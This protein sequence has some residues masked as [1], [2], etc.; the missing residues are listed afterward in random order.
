MS[1]ASLMGKARLNAAR[2]GIMAEDNPVKEH[3]RQRGEMRSLSWWFKKQEMTPARRGLMV[4][5]WLVIGALVYFQFAGGSHP[6]NAITTSKSAAPAQPALATA[7]KLPDAGATGAIDAMSAA[8]MPPKEVS[9]INVIRKARADYA[10][11]STDMQKGAV[12]PRRAKAIRAALQAPQVE[13]WIGRAV[14]ITTNGE[15]KGVLTVAI[16]DN[17]TLAT[18]NNA[19]SDIGSNTLVEADTPVYEAMLT[20]SKGDLVRFSGRFFK[21]DEDGIDE[22]SFT[23]TGSIEEPEFTFRF[24]ALEKVE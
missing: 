9:F 5:A 20:L 22:Q 3:E 1:G 4:V 2:G 15:G 21:D 23:M 12:R 8:Q 7:T 11:A 17:L 10:E 13:N 14:K 24:T 6:K 19:F 18:W 16:D